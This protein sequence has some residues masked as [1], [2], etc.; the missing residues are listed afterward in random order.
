MR[1]SRTLIQTIVLL[2][3]GTYVAAYALQGLPTDDL[4]KPLGAA[5]SIVGLFVLALDKYLW[6]TPRIGRLVTKR[7]NVIGTW[8]GTLASHWINPE[9]GE[10]VA[11]DPEVYLV[12]RQTLWGVSANLITRESKSCSTTATIED[13][14]CGQ[15]QLTALYRNTPRAAVRH[16]SEVHH[17]AFKLDISGEPVD[18]LEGFYWT[19]RNTMGEFEFDTRFSKT[20]ESY[21]AAQALD[22]PGRSGRQ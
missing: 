16:R 3:A 15:Y 12:V 22:S 14:G 2:V 9:T 10:R 17:G 19:D 6:R 5:T 20:V 13:D 8:R 7:P 18:R 21:A 11:P 4:L 1:P